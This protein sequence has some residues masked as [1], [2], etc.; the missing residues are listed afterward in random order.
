MAKKCI[1]VRWQCPWYLIS[2]YFLP[3]LRRRGRGIFTCSSII[4]CSTTQWYWYS[5]FNPSRGS[6][7]QLWCRGNRHQVWASASTMRINL[8]CM[9]W[10][11]G[12]QSTRRKPTQEQGEYA[13]CAQKGPCRDLDL[14]AVKLTKPHYL[15]IILSV[16]F[17]DITFRRIV[18]KQVRWSAPLT[19][20]GQSLIRSPLSPSG[21]LC[22]IWIW[23]VSASTGT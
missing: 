5:A 9:F 18:V 13:N 15:L 7:G 22:Q 2:L 23:N 14:L 1:F 20:E 12:K 10:W 17:W 19:F 4:Q 16:H 11:W 3:N 6:S 21:C 8:V